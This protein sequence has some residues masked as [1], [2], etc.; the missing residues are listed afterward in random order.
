MRLS[1]NPLNTH[2][3]WPVATPH[4]QKDTF[5]EEAGIWVS[6]TS[7]RLRLLR[8]L[9]EIT[10]PRLKCIALSRTNASRVDFVCLNNVAIYP[11]AGLITAQKALLVYLACDLVGSR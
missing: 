11:V 1:H 5:G 8:R 9:L 10:S 4:P 2:R 7:P 3:Q 6:L